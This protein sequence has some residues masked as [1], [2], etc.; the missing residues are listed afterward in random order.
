VSLS[1]EQFG[2]KECFGAPAETFWASWRRFN[3]VERL[4]DESHFIVRI[5]AC[6]QC[7][8]RYVAVTTEMIDWKGGDDPIY[9]S[10]LPLSA[11][12]AEMLLHQGANVDV[13]AIERLGDKRRYLKVDW[14]S[15]QQQF[16]GWA[17]G[18]LRI[19][20]HD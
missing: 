1:E 12:E 13:K 5:V 14:P 3:E 9:R 7:G 15:G 4:V 19:G 16:I 8:Q 6:S 18:N 2:C 20:P 11:A 10:I 17:T